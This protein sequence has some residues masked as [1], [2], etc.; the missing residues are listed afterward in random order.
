MLGYGVR[1]QEGL[2][3]SRTTRR[4]QKIGIHFPGC[5]EQH[6]VGRTNRENVADTYNSTFFSFKDELKD[7]RKVDATGNH[8]IK[9]NDPFKKTNIVYFLICR[10]CK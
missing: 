8:Y 2:P 6:V 3:D 9:Q 7:G 10:F 4:Q 5:S 1:L